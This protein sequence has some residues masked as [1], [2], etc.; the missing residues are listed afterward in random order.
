LTNI[1]SNQPGAVIRVCGPEDLESLV[2]LGRQTFYDTFHTM[3]TPENMQA[4]LDSAFDPET[5]AAELDNPGIQYYYLY[6]GQT[7]VGYLKLNWPGFQTDCNDPDSL[8]IERIYVLKSYQGCGFGRMLVNK[9]LDIAR[10]SGMKS[11]WLGVWQKNTA[12]IGFYR[13]MGFKTFATHHFTLGAEHQ[14]DDLMRLELEH[15]DYVDFSEYY[16]YDHN[17]TQ[18]IPFYLQYA[19]ECQSP[20]LELACG[21]GRILIPL[22]QAGYEISGIDISENMLSTCRRAVEQAG[23]NGRVHLSQTDMAHFD[24][25]RKDFHLI[26][27][28]LRSFMHLLTPAEQRSCL[29]QVKRHLDPKGRFIL[30]LIAPDPV[31]LK[32]AVSQ[33]FTVRRAFDLPNGHHVVR[34]ERLA[35]HDPQTQV[36]RFEFRFEEFDPKGKLVRERLVPLFTRYSYHDELQQLLEKTGFQVLE[37]FRDYNGHPYDGTGEMIIVAQHS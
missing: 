25:A 35:E 10:Q 22:A 15:G 9:S 7:L 28:A 3:N 31:R 32:Q 36:R 21:T 17:F 1:N 29:R 11:V 16:D 19:E 34:K 5:I 24:L 18:D 6:L 20:I 2:A 30:S 23:V 12:A 14:T 13:R 8:E 27:I 37:E 4:Y 26:L 33:E